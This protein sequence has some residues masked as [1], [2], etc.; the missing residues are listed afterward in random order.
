MSNR[1]ADATNSKTS[2]TKMPDWG[3]SRTPVGGIVGGVAG[4]IVAIGLAAFSILRQKKQKKVAA[5]T[6]PMAYK[7]PLTEQ[8]HHHG[9]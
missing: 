3:D 1:T 2:A 8:Q 7:S 5:T 9:S 4:G 6:A